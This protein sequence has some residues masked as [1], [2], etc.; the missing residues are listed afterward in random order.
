MNPFFQTCLGHLVMCLPSY[1]Y[2]IPY[3][4]N[5]GNSPFPGFSSIQESLVAQNKRIYPITMCDS[6]SHCGKDQCWT[7]FLVSELLHQLFLKAP[8]LTESK[9]KIPPCG[10]LSS[11]YILMGKW[12]AKIYE[13]SDLGCKHNNPKGSAAKFIFVPSYS[14]IHKDYWWDHGYFSL[15]HK[16]RA[17]IYQ[18]HR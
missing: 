6:G 10:A 5:E 11:S 16:W 3:F 7:T 13:V 1:N 8:S 9:V 14:I 18:G 4:Q 2:I 12:L 15:V 17:H